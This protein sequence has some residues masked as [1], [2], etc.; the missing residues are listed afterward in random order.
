M[1]IL[2]VTK[3]FS[4]TTGKDAVLQDFGREIRLGEALQKR[5]S[6]TILA[7]DH[8]RKEK[9]TR[10][11]HR[12]RA[13]V[14]PFTLLKIPE[15]LGE[16]RRFAK[17]SDIVVGTT[18]PLFAFLAYLAKGRKKFVYD[19]RDNYETY[20]FASLPLMRKGI[21]GRTLM[22]LVNNFLIRKADLAVCVSQSLKSKVGR[23]RKGRTIVVENGIEGMFKPMPM[24]K[25][26]KALK[27]PENA[28][29]ITY[30]GHVS[31]ERGA[32]MLLAAFARIRSKYKDAVL[33]LSGKVDPEINI[34]QPGIIWLELPRRE[35][36]VMGINAANVAVLPQPENETS[37]YTFPYKLME[38][39][40]CN[41]RVVA[42]AIG[43]VKEVLKDH[44]DQLARPEAHD[45]AE[46]IIA[47]LRKKGKA[48]YNSIVEKYSWQRLGDKLEESISAFAAQEKG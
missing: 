22:R 27:L 48:D 15:F 35:D 37:R 10:Y 9:F 42:T 23:I 7:G 20:D 28:P 8:E 30:I 1:R 17:K 21:I 33:L 34:K 5:H 40:A 41:T 19:L 31:A 26:R 3:R 25:C 45:L 43:D 12:M 47:C 24:E 32:K 2:I 13:E 29:I 14:R 36:V 4:S 6:V 39:M 38:Y 46:K 18:H 11:M 16:A 44:P